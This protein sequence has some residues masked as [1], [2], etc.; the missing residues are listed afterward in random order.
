MI[1][2]APAKVERETVGT[3]AIAGEV[4]GKGRW[5]EFILLA[6]AGGSTDPPAGAGSTRARRIEPEQ[7]TSGAVMLGHQ[8]QAA[9]IG[10][11][12]ALLRRGDRAEREDAR[13]RERL[14]GGPERILLC[15]CAH[16]QEPFE[17]HAE[18]REPLGIG[19]AVLEE[20]L[21]RRG[22]EDQPAFRR[23]QRPGEREAERRDMVAMG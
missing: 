2:N 3:G 20:I 15:L 5:A 4:D 10:Q 18:M 8:Q 6:L 14:F 9:R 12:H 21:L 19:Q 13:R 17:R 16:E 22:P 23:H 7:Q 11:A 1:V